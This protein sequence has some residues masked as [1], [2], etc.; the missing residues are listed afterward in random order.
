MLTKPQRQEKQIESTTLLSRLNSIS[1]YFIPSFLFE[2]KPPI[3]H[4]VRP[5]TFKGH[6][7]NPTLA[8]NTT[9][10]PFDVTHLVLI[11]E[12]VLDIMPTGPSERKISES[13]K[14]RVIFTEWFKLQRVSKSREVSMCP[15][16][17]VS[18]SRH[19]FPVLHKSLNPLP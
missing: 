2:N 17:G 4:L 11:T 18:S 8:A 13:S 6:I 3:V 7:F 19:V 1:I 16:F 14:M 9:L 10:L 15:N 5:G 12:E